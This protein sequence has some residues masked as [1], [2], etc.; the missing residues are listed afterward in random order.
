MCGI[1]R[2]LWG[3][4]RVSRRE[5]VA[6]SSALGSEHAPVLPSAVRMIVPTWTRVLVALASF[7]LGGFLIIQGSNLG[8]VLLALSAYL[9]VGYFRYGTV[10]LAFRAVASG[11]A[12]RAA[13]L[14]DGV[15]NPT[16]LRAADRAYFEL[17][18]GF[19]CAA[20]AKNDAAEQHL[21]LALGNPL[22]SEDDR[23]LAETVLAQLLVARDQRDEARTLLDCAS[24]RCRRT[25]VAERIRALRA[26][27]PK[28]G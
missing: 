14:L 27:L 13:Q 23:A 7:V 21:R 6:W 10:S 19:V 20:R 17:A 15:K 11:N 4:Q 9:A 22:R 25:A 2:L 5:A 1:P 16:S 26:E 3:L 12:E 24:A 28:S 8:L 18:S